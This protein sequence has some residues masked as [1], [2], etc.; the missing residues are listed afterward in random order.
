M[1]YSE[2]FN[3]FYED[4]NNFTNFLYKDS[5]GSGYYKFLLKNFDER[6]KKIYLP[7]VNFLNIKSQL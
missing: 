7:K 3:G 2:I 5:G 6:V 4:T 1:F